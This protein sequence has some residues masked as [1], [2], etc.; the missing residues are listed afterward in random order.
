MNSTS[1]GCRLVSS[2]ARSPARAITGPEVARKL[3]PSSRA[4]IW[5]SVVLPSPGGPTNSTWSSASLRARAA[6]MN[7]ERLARACACPMNSERRCGRSETSASSSR[8]SGGVRGG[9]GGRSFPHLLPPQPNQLRRLGA[10][11]GTARGRR[12][13]G[14]GLRLTIAEIDQ[15]RD[16]IRNRLRGAPLLHRAGEAHHRGIDVGV[17]RRLVLQLGD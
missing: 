9:G 7:T 3:T 5:A 6:S 1:R 10:L 17:F 13:G 15:R 2:A 4:T 12:D 14:R 16:R 8:R 11:A